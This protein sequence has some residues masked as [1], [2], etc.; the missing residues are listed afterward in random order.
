LF[1][2]QGF[3]GVT[4]DEIAVAAGVARR[5]LF[6]LFP[7]K[8]DLLWHGLYEFR[9][10]I[11]GA[12]A[13]FGN[14]RLTPREVVAQIFVPVLGSLGAPELASLARRKLTLLASA[15]AL[16][17]HPMLQEIEAVLA[18]TLA[19]KALPRDVPPE[20]AARALVAATFGSLLWWAEHG[21]RLSAL[22]ATLGALEAVSAAS[23]GETASPSGER[24][25][26]PASSGAGARRDPPA[27]GTSSGTRPRPR[28]RAPR[29]GT[30]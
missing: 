20:L 19:P 17:N 29:P 22:D 1:E 16:L 2:T 27:R 6:R 8:A 9:V 30:R 18:K 13:S 10:A 14:E 15:P 21:N 28:P 26:L 7:T 11:E 24:R 23:A 12:A 4:M 5:T 25:P 3:D